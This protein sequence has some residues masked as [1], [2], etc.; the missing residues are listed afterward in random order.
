MVAFMVMALLSVLGSDSAVAQTNSTGSVEATITWH[1]NDVI[2]SKGDAGAVLLLFSEPA[3][4]QLTVADVAT[5][6]PE[7]LPWHY[8]DTIYGGYGEC[9]S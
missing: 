6:K 1:Y 8:T 3:L 5:I 9:W 2:G 4:H 7:V